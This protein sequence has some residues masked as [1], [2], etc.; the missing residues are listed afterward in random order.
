MVSQQTDTLEERFLEPAQARFTR[1]PDGALRLEIEGERC[2]L[3][4]KPSRAFPISDA[5]RYIG[6]Y[7]GA[8][9][10]IGVI[11]D[12]SELHPDSRLEL[13]RELAKRYFCP[14]IQRVLSVRSEFGVLS[15]RVVTDKGERGFSVRDPR[16]NVFELGGGRLIMIDAEG[17]RYEIPDL[18][19][20]D[21]RTRTAIERVL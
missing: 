19:C 1:G 5:V 9:T 8:N 10:D 16:E 21:R 7:D 6:L 18:A 14:V 3:R 13:E 15:L 17:N 12:P 2:V 20:M 11:R 4:V